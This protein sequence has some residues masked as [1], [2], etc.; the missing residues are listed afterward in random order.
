MQPDETDG[1]QLRASVSVEMKV[2][3]GQYESASAFISLQGIAPDTSAE[4]IEGALDHAKLAW[5]ALKPRLQAKVA[6][7]RKE[8]GF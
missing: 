8:R 1:Q 2:N 7:M 5:D 3:L 4:E 6:E